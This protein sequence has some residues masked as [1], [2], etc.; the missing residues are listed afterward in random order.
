MYNLVIV[1]SPTKAKTLSRFLDNSFRIESS[2]GHVR[3]L[4]QSKLGIDVEKD[5]DPQYQ[6]L[7]SKKKRV[8]ELKEALKDA[9]A[10]YLATDPDREGE[11]IAWHLLT[12]LNLNKEKKL[13]IER[14]VFHEITPEALQA[15]LAHPRNIDKHLVDAQQ[16][17]RVL[18]RLVGYELSP[19]LWRKIRKGLSAGRVQSV[20]VRLI[21]EREKEIE[22]F[23][24]V[25]YWNIT[26][27]FQKEKKSFTA[28]LL[29][30]DNQKAEITNQ[31]QAEATTAD[32]EKHA[33]T[34]TKKTVKA[35]NRSPYP[36]F[37]TSTL[38]QGA[39]NILGWP[40]KRTMSIAQDLYEMGHISYMRTDSVNLAKSAV[41]QTRDFIKNTIGEKYV[42]L[43][44]RSYKTKSKVAQEAHEAIRPTNPSQTPEK[45]AAALN[46]DQLKLYDLIWKRMVACQMTDARMEQVGIDIQGGKYL[47]RT[48][49]TK[50]LFDGWKKLQQKEPSEEESV[51][52]ASIPDLNEGDKVNLVRI[53]PEQKFTEPPPRYNE[54]SLIKTLEEQGI[55]RPSTYASII[56]TI[57][58][59]QYVEKKERRFYP[60]SLGIGV[61]TFLVKYF[62][63]IIDVSFTAKMEDDLD[64]IA[65]GEVAWKPIIKTFYEPFK[66]KLSKVTETAERVKIETEQTDEK[67]ELCGSPMVIRLGKYGK[68]L[69]CS[70]F[71]KCKNTKPYQEKTDVLCPKCGGAIVIRKTK[72]GRVFYGCSNYPKCTFASW[73]KPENPPQTV[74]S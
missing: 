7:S 10:L 52:N 34:I 2:F 14:I 30:I 19:L 68:F 45:M 72:R 26:V 57:Q 29:E 53:I 15:A 58:E 1:E 51:E 54:G 44:P 61:N 70:T 32:L 31:K 38:Q 47:L 43:E 21:V 50:T 5:F 16:A 69:A 59:R 3:D 20:A 66:E 23:V 67:C 49:A 65:N 11:A 40:A 36:P 56:S 17:R 48:N 74:T 71:P 18:D 4:P 12:A 60:T 37:T 55:G 73:N 42:P 41:D 39:S 9:K 27:E 63:G 6:V 28:K 8:T 13:P 35:V 33:Y 46:K 64:R 22:A 24:P 25:E 62:S